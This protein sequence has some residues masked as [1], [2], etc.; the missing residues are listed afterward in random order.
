MLFIPVVLHVA[1]EWQAQSELSVTNFRR[2]WCCAH[3][4]LTPGLTTSDLIQREGAKG[5]NCKSV[6]GCV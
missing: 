6:P 4:N 1:R 5:Q 3:N 2:A